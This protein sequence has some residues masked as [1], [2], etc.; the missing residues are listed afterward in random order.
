[1][2]NL[3]N[4]KVT[5]LKFNNAVLV[6]KNLYSLCS[7][8]ILNLYIVYRLNNRPH[9]PSNNFTLK[10]CLFGRVKLSRNMVKSKF[11]YNGRGIAFDGEGNEFGN[12][13]A[14]NNVNFGVDNKSLSHTNNRK[15]NFL[16][17]GE[18]PTDGI[19]D[20]TGAAEKKLVLTLVK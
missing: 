17:L 11:I 14:R 3:A 19:N 9:N 2:S 7:N 5:N 15:N 13:F 4:G 20:S 1:M 6:Q 12:E 16:V 8:F 18:V 10:N